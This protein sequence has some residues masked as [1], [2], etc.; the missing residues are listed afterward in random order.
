[1]TPDELVKE[2]KLLP[3]KFVQM[4]LLGMRKPFHKDSV[5]DYPGV[6]IPLVAARRHKSVRRGTSDDSTTPSVDSRASG[7]VVERTSSKFD[8]DVEGGR[9][10]ATSSQR[11]VGTTVEDLR[12]E[13]EED[14]AALGIDSVY[15][16]EFFILGL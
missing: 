9:S 1:V 6:L 13:V 14:L 3:R 16:R 11:S 15:D 2:I 7:A 5:D 10:R 8:P 4:P 12:H